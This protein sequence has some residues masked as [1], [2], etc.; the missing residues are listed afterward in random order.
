MGRGG[1]HTDP[2]KW[3]MKEGLEKSTPCL[4]QSPKKGRGEDL[5]RNAESISKE[6]EGH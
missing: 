3:E 6:S 1:A 5:G 4:A 2:Q